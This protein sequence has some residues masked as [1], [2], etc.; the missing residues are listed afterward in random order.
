MQLTPFG[1]EVK[2]AI[3]EALGVPI[4]ELLEDVSVS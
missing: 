2:A 1:D 4:G 3:R